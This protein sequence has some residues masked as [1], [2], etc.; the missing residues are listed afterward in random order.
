MWFPRSMSESLVDPEDGAFSPEA[1]QAMATVLQSWIRSSRAFQRSGVYPLHS[2]VVD[3]TLDR[4]SYAL[5]RELAHGGPR[6]L[7]D[8]AQATSMTASH[9]S[10]TVDSLVRRGLVARTVPDGDR[11]VTVLDVTEV[12]HQVGREIERRFL[13]LLSQRF[14]SFDEADLIAFGALFHRFADVLVRWSE[15]VGEAVAGPDTAPERRVGIGRHEHV[16]AQ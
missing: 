13:A 14:T 2:T 1:T 11:R 16:D 8:L 6:R 10:R 4:V 5:L 3:V 15:E 12:G 7:G 9:A